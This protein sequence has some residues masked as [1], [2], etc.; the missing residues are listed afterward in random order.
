MEEMPI[1]NLVAFT[2]EDLNGLGFAALAMRSRLLLGKRTGSFLTNVDSSR[3]VQFS[4]SPKAFPSTVYNL[5]APC[6]YFWCEFLPPPRSYQQE[7]HV[8]GLGKLAQS[9]KVFAEISDD[10]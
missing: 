4:Q 10:N 7:S 6:L 2:I 1:V 3:A 5:H 9:L 8:F